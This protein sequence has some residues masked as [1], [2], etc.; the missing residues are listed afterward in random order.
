MAREHLRADKEVIERLLSHGSTEE[1]RGA[2]DRTQYF[3]DR[4]TLVQDWADYLDK[5][6]TGA[7]IIQI[8][9]GKAGKAAWA[10]LAVKGGVRSAP[11]LSF[12][13]VA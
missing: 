1:L 10:R 6:R 11:P 13:T 2:Y 3:A 9:F 12:V 4:I 5:L 8:D 7:D